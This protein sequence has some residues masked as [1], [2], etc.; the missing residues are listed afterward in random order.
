MGLVFSA[1][2]HKAHCDGPIVT[3]VNERGAAL[4]GVVLMLMML[5]GLAAAL[6]LNGQTETTISF[7]QRSQAQARA[8][9]E[10]GLS[11]A[12]QVVTAHIG[13]WQANGFASPSDALDALLLGPDG[14]SG[15]E[16]LD[17]DNF[18]LEEV[19][20]WGVA[21]GVRFPLQGVSYAEY[22]AIL[23][24]DDDDG[25]NE[26]GDAVNDQ[27]GTL[28][29]R[30]TGYAS[31]NTMAV[32][33][34]RISSTET[35]AML[36]DGDLKI[37]D[38]VV[39]GGTAGNVHANG[40]L[41][42]DGTEV[43]VSGGLT[44]GG[45]YSGYLPGTGGVPQIPV[46]AVNAS[47]HRPR[48]DFILTST[49]AMTDLAGTVLCPSTEETCNG[50]EFKGDGWESDKTTPPAGTYYI[51]GDAEIK[52]KMGAE[53]SPAQ[54][55]IIAEG[56]IKISGTS[57]IVSNDP[58]VLLVTDG[59]LVI[60]GSGVISGVP[61]EETLVKQIFVGRMLVHEQVKLKNKPTITGVLIVENA[62]SVDGLVNDNEMTD[63]VS[64]SYSG[65]LGST[66][67][68]AVSG[69]RDVR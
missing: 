59:D 61:G 38:E 40:N 29:L 20:G 68:F 48:A 25:P 28:T 4:I 64:L 52:G 15:T 57:V 58:D 36:I 55:T 11:H 35:P 14:Q 60:E 3:R 18:S 50:W 22:D 8:A 44:A 43:Q 13:Q 67:G 37:K 53:A 2:I 69:W 66:A 33:E 19:D 1:V 10:A 56:S 39:I 47:D 51:E 23:R 21:P 5:S 16:A 62:Q 31:D 9:A 41:T 54:L 7:N 17:A 46:P 49:G 42:I 26:D 63:D 34:V 6:A 32:L 24:D 65:E 45:Q 30:A 27:N 12:V